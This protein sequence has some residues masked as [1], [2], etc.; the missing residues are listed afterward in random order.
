MDRVPERE[1]LRIGEVYH[2][3]D[4]QLAEILHKQLCAAD[5]LDSYEIE[6]VLGIQD[7]RPLTWKQR[8]FARRLLCTKVGSAWL[9]LHG[10]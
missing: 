7:G 10:F 2:Y 3:T 5:T 4:E 9:A 8:R 1:H 6:F